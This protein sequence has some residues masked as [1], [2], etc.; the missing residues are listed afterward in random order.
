MT[1]IFRQLFDKESSTYTYII[2]DSVSREACIIDPV[3]E[4]LQRDLKVINELNLKLTWALDT[5]IHADHI[6]AADALRRATGCKT[7]GAKSAGL[8]CADKLLAEG[9]EI[10]AGA[11]H[12]KVLELPGHTSESI[13]FLVGDKIFTGDALLIR[14]CGRT[15]FQNGNAGT[16]YDSIHKK[17]FTLPDATLIYPAHDYNG[18]T[19]SSVA[20]EKKF[21][22]RLTL[23]R[24]K[25]IE[26]MANLNLPEPKKI[27]EALP[28]NQRCG[29]ATN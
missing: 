21:N 22:P 24:D 10:R 1:E 20:E 26:F 18:L 8:A 9:D 16:L 4:Q 5:H 14:G 19:V 15:D 28:S 11:I 6:T 29:S 2:G 27:R 3:V 25:F 7:A 17:V 13:G 23:S 12:I